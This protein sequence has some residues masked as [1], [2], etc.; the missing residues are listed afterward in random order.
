MHTVEAA[1]TRD[2]GFRLSGLTLNADE[3]IAVA[4]VVRRSRILPASLV[5]LLANR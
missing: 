2:D 5:T 4:G 3:T 1:G